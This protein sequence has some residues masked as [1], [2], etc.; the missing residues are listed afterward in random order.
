VEI[1]ADHVEALA[2]ENRVLR[3][4]LAS[5]ESWARTRDRAARTAPARQAAASRFVKLARERFGDLPE[6]DLQLAAEQLKKA[7]F[8]KLAYAAAEA[9]RRQLVTK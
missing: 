3:A 1:A 7:Y 5:H 2:A 6:Q 8:T 9:R 4:K